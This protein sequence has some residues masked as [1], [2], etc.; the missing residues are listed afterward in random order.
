MTPVPESGLPPCMN[1]TAF[2]K[3]GRMINSSPTDGAAVGEWTKTGSSQFAATFMGFAKAGEDFLLLKVRATAE[4]H[5]S[6]DTFAGPYQVDIF[7]SPGDVVITLNGTV[8]G[9]RFGVGPLE[10][11]RP[12]CA[13]QG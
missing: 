4:V 6:G 3:D 13:G 1:L 5:K 8:W 7:D 2:S 10:R 12:R 11:G 9:T